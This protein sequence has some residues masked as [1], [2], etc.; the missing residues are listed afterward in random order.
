MKNLKIASGILMATAL[1]S[2]SCSDD[3]DHNPIALE[4]TTFTLNDP[5]YKANG[6]I[7]E[8]TSGIGLTWSQPA[9]GVPV[10]ATY[11]LEM[12][13]V[14]DFSDIPTIDDEGNATMMSSVTTLA[15]TKE[16][17]SASIKG[18][19][20]NNAIL[21]NYNV[22]DETSFAALM[23]LT[24]GQVPVYIRATSTFNSETIY[25]NVVSFTAIPYFVV[26][27][28]FTP[29]YLIGALN[30]WTPS[31]STMN[32][33]LYPSEEGT[34]S[35]TTQWTGD[36]NLKFWETDDWGNWSSAWSTPTDGDN[37]P[38]GS[39]VKDGSGAMVCPEP[40]AFYTYT[41]NMDEQ[42][43]TWT[44]LDNQSPAEFTSISLIGINGDWETDY[45][46]EQVYPH[47]WCVKGFTF[48]AKTEFKFRADNDWTVNWG[49]AVD[50]S[51][52]PYGLG[53][54]NGENMSTGE[55][56]FDIYFNDITGEFAFV[57]AK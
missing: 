26:P 19:D 52:T 12:S 54:S 51:D 38:S 16:D 50:M 2:V 24:D 57:A 11:T 42:T 15:T 13:T 49:V 25:S 40:G 33:L 8:K 32:A 56:T 41:I 46:L 23:L 43:Y 14:E 22:S 5:A 31:S 44:R 1:L 30:G 55:G 39:L 3:R 36:G 10:V 29:Y 7:L 6:I 17:I 45:P 20:V 28:S 27:E 53:K 47:N 35:Y 18:K 34:Y 4:P 9:Y 37:S 21:K 48:S